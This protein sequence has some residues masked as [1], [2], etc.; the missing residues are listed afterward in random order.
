MGLSPKLQLGLTMRR[1]E[2]LGRRRVG[3]GIL[4]SA[5]LSLLFATACLALGC[6]DGTSSSPSPP[7]LSLPP[8]ASA[9]PFSSHNVL[10]PLEPERMPLSGVELQ[11]FRSAWYNDGFAPGHG[12]ADIP[13]THGR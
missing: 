4:S 13:T 7:A 8:E 11:E 5:P 1:F 2:D 6:R 10:V 9:L 3:L 12:P